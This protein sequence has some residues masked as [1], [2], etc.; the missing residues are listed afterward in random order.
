MDDPLAEQRALDLGRWLSQAT[1]DDIY[2]FGYAGVAHCSICGRAEAAPDCELEED[3]PIPQRMCRAGL[4]ASG[5][6]TCA[7]GLRREV[8]ATVGPWRDP[9]PQV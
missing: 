7:P 6:A 9:R 4:D 1:D 3:L 8:P 5:D 2:E